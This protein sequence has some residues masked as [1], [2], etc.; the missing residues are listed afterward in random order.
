MGLQIC[1]F[2]A[3]ANVRSGAPFFPAAYHEGDD[4]VFA[5]A[6]EAADLAVEAFSN[7]KTLD[8]GRRLLISEIEKHGH[9]ISKVA[10]TQLWHIKFG[11][12]DF[13]LAPFPDDAHSLGGAVEKMGVPKIGLHGSLAAAAILTEAVDR[14]DFPHLVSADSC[15]RCWKILSLPNALP[16]GH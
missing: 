3:L 2:A 7:E 16:K 11:G 15:N 4:P 12:I 10:A 1:R 9:A 6:T 8:E 14:A 5:I 13:S